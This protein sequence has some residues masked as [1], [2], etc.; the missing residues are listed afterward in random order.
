[1]DEIPLGSLVTIAL[2]FGGLPSILVTVLA[3]GRGLVILFAVAAV[4]L[5]SYLLWFF[6]LRPRNDWTG[7]EGLGLIVLPGLLLCAGGVGFLAYLLV[8]AVGM[9]PVQRKQKRSS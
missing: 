7:L 3:G 5:A 8:G 9:L 6:G 2:L 1:M 4:C